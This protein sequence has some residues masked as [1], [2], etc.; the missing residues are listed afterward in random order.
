ML[1]FLCVNGISMKYT[2]PLIFFI[3]LLCCCSENTPRPIGYNRIELPTYSYQNFSNQYFSFNRSTF[4][5]V[6]TVHS[7]DQTSKWFNIV[8]PDYNAKIYCS[9]TRINNQRLKQYLEDSYRFAYS[10]AVK[11]DDINQDLYLNPERKTY[12]ILYSIGGDVATPVQFFLTD[13]VSNFFRGSL[14]FDTQVNGDSISP[15][16]EF[17]KTD[18]INLIETFEWKNK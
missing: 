11:A 13:S 8:Y 12:G 16:I 3:V 17:I 9:Y 10:H 15:V 2:T 7:E 6:D 4:S 18:I 1:T 5:I 14:Y